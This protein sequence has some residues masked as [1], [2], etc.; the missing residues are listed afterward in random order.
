[1]FSIKDQM[2]IYKHWYT[3]GKSNPGYNIVININSEQ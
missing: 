2:V 1:M 3:M